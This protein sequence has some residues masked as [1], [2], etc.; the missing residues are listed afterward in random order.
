[1]SDIITPLG[2]KITVLSPEVTHDWLERELPEG[3]VGLV[4]Q[5]ANPSDHRMSSVI[6]SPENCRELAE[7]LM[8][9]GQP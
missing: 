3:S 5:M 2:A 4:L 8:E 9:W 6:L 1:M 7:Q